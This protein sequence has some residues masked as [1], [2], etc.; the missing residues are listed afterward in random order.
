MRSG[1]NRVAGNRSGAH[2]DPNARLLAQSGHPSRDQQ[3]P[4]LGV[5]RR[6]DNSNGDPGGV[7]HN[8]FAMILAPSSAALHMFAI[9]TKRTCQ[10][11]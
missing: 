4:L 5:K 8:D 1:L 3:C 6:H 10:S 7:A 9:G 2:L 11:P